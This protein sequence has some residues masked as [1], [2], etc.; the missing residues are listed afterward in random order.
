MEFQ[1]QLC[2]LKLSV[3]IIDFPAVFLTE[4][5]TALDLN[6]DTINSYRKK[7]Y[8]TVLN[9]LYKQG[10]A[11]RKETA[12]GR[13]YAPL[14]AGY[15]GRKPSFV[16]KWVLI[17]HRQVGEIRFQNSCTPRVLPITSEDTRCPAI[18]CP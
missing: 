17:C 3:F 15:N 9:K 14:D 5:N 7:I 1:E 8:K 16:K 18:G 10:A 4:V 6:R 13:K 11:I 12:T 2:P